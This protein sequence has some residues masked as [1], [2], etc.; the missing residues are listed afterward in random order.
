[1]EGE[2]IRGVVLSTIAERRPDLKRELGI[3]RQALL[4]EDQEGDGGSSEEE[5]KVYA[6]YLV[7]GGAIVT[8]LLFWRENGVLLLSRGPI[9]RS[10]FLHLFR[11]GTRTVNFMLLRE[12]WSGP[13][14][15][16]C[17][18]KARVSRAIFSRI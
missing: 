13:W 2:E 5:L 1:M 7:S 9:L 10:L 4:L 6:R 16:S 17:A 3:L 15:S 12:E 18:I 8:I 14:M 11:V